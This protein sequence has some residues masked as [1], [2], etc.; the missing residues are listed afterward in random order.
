M[1]HICGRDY[2]PRRR[3][4]SERLGRP[5]VNSGQVHPPRTQGPPTLHW[6]VVVSGAAHDGGGWR[7]LRERG[8]LPLPARARAAGAGVTGRNGTRPPACAAAQTFR[9]AAR[10]A[11]GEAT[12]LCPSR[13]G[14][15]GQGR[16]VWHQKPAPLPQTCATVSLFFCGCCV[17]LGRRSWQLASSE[18]AGACLQC[19]LRAP[20]PA[21]AALPCPV[22]FSSGFRCGLCGWWRRCRSLRRRASEG[23]REPRSSMTLHWHTH[24]SPTP[25]GWVRHWTRRLGTQPTGGKRLGPAC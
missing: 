13:A 2:T 5:N 16:C 25:S 15:R 6:R 24:T 1:I 18:A 8:A 20:K 22:L 23:A 17:V 12:A 4:S 9:A 19:L 21:D 11:A 3:P 14:E 7:C 10:G